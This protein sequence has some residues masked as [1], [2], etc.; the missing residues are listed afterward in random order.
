MVSD[1]LLE[2]QTGCSRILDYFKQNDSSKK[3][4]ITGA[5][6]SGKSF[7]LKKINDYFIKQSRYYVIQ[8]KANSNPLLAINDFL[9]FTTFLNDNEKLNTLILKEKATNVLKKISSKLDILFTLINNNQIIPSVYSN[10]EWGII[11]RLN[12]LIPYVNKK[13]VFICDD[14]DKWD[15]PSVNLLCKMIK[16]TNT[17]KWLKKASFIF[18]ATNNSQ[19]YNY[20]SNTKEY[21]IKIFNLHEIDVDTLKRYFFHHN[22]NMDAEKVFNLTNGNI[23]L[24]SE[25]LDNGVNQLS[26]EKYQVYLANTI[27][28]IVNDKHKQEDTI[29]MINKSSIVGPSFHKKML[30]EISEFNNNSFMEYLYYAKAGNIYYEN[31]SI[32]TFKTK[33]LWQILRD[34][35]INN[36]LY[37]MILANAIK[38]LIPSHFFLRAQENNIADNKNEAVEAYFNFVIEYMKKYHKRIIIAPDFLSILEEFDLYESMNKILYAYENYFNNE[39]EEARKALDFV[40][41]NYFVNFQKDY[42]MTLI[43]INETILH[44][45]YNDALT[46]IK[47]YTLNISFEKSEPYLW[48]QASILQLEISFELF[49][50]TKELYNKIIHMFAQY[51]E[52]DEQ[53]RI[54]YFNFKSKNNFTFGIDLSHKESLDSYTFFL[55]AKNL[56]SKDYYAT[57]LI[58]YLANTLVLGDYTKVMEISEKN[59]EMFVKHNELRN[60]IPVF[61]NNYFLAKILSNNDFNKCR[62]NSYIEF[63][64]NVINNVKENNIADVLYKIN[65]GVAYFMNEN[66]DKALLLYKTLYQRYD[67]EDYDDYYKYHIIN[68]YNIILNYV[69]HSNDYEFINDLKALNPLPNNKVFF[70]ARNEYLLNINFLTCTKQSLTFCMTSHNILGKAWSFWGRP[71]LFTDIQYWSD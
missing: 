1:E 49:I 50:E 45:N 67:K 56:P 24:I 39:F 13:I 69:N 17:P 61:T 29:S 59:V 54:E 52:T 30:K 10:T 23:G 58:N 6:K 36:S 62:L 46:L 64:E 70:D 21:G 37:H 22:I 34:Y 47:N 16:W 42:L 28:G 18:S 41:I 71:L 66:L 51:I 2:K 5:F 55:N 11:E 14:I 40:S 9:P 32:V 31:N 48:L 20:F 8:L 65:L 44:S 33:N 19:I 57:A 25:I 38:K 26:P 15:W 12:N 35:N 3:V 27:N 63:L 4:F 53:F 43:L 60:Y 7:V 68:N